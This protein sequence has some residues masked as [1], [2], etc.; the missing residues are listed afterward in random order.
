VMKKLMAER[1]PIYA[2]ADVTVESRDVPH[3]T[4]VGTVVDAL[5]DKL[6][7]AKKPAKDQSREK[8]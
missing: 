5:A 2:E 6:G 4:I 1:Y 7:C 3:D 8:V